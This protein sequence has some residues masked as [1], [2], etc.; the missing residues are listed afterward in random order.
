MTAT[1]RA[2]HEPAVDVNRCQGRGR[3]FIGCAECDP[4]EHGFEHGR[5]HVTSCYGAQRVCEGATVDG[6]R[7]GA[8]QHRVVRVHHRPVGR[9]PGVEQAGSF[10]RRLEA[11]SC[12]LVEAGGEVDQRPQRAAG[13]AGAVGGAE[14]QRLGPRVLVCRQPRV[15]G[16]Q[17][18][19]VGGE[20][21]TLGGQRGELS[22]QGLLGGARAVRYELTGHGYARL[23]GARDQIRE[24]LGERLVDRELLDALEPCLEP[25]EQARAHGF[26]PLGRLRPLGLAL[27][28]ARFASLEALARGGQR[29]LGRRERA[30]QLRHRVDR[31]GAAC[32][33]LI[34]EPADRLDRAL[35]LDQTRDCSRV[36]GDTRIRR[37]L[38]AALKLLLDEAPLLLERGARARGGDAQFVG[39]AFGSV[40]VGFCLRRG[41]LRRGSQAVKLLEPLGG[42]PVL[43][44]PQLPLAGARRRELLVERGAATA[45]RG[46]PLTGAP[47]RRLRA[48]QSL[49][50]L[51]TDVCSLEQQVAPLAQ[52]GARPIAI[53]SCERRHRGAHLP[54]L[55]QLCPQAVELVEPARDA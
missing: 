53:G 44:G 2:E 20:R 22:A 6:L 17:R 23:T 12:R 55:G 7:P 37:G 13:A 42:A 51:V 35:L 39:F 14:R 1:Q 43:G 52:R 9:H 26:E 5:A 16:R 3:V 31:L 29:L 18:L 28:L 27:A 4:R 15:L 8:Y 50:A 46:P 30:H 47:N 48:R 33:E 11:G 24:L 45:Q 40:E 54:Q 41:P 10:E 36:I 34:E 32:G 49:D 21:G 25:L 19:A 38:D